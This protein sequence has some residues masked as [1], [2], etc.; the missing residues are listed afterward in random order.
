MLKYIHTVKEPQ[1]AIEAKTDPNKRF[2]SSL[3]AMR[4]V[5]A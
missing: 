4:Y 3:T 1:L 2:I 5:D